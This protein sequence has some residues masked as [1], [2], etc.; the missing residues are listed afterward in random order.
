MASQRI[1]I[2]KVGGVTADLIEQRLREWS[3]ARQTD[4]PNLW[5]SE[6]WPQ[7]VRR[8]ADDFAERLRAHAFTPPVVHFVEWADTWSMGDLFGRWLTPP[9]GSMPLAV[10]ADRFE[11]FAHALPDGGH[12]SQHLASSGPQQFVESDWFVGR[13]REAVGAWRGLV[14]RA[15]VIVLRQVVAGSVLDEEITESLMSVPDWL[16]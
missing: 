3:A 15:V 14:D 13:L 8:Q 9:D 5:S 12:L 7:H 6:Q 16:S 2:A 11:I 4:N 10:H 1:T